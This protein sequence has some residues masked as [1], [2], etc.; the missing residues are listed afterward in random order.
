MQGRASRLFYC[1]VSFVLLLLK[2]GH[3]GVRPA[4]ERR[5]HAANM[6]NIVAALLRTTLFHWITSTDSTLPRPLDNRIL[7][8]I[9][10]RS[11]HLDQDLLLLKPPFEAPV[12]GCSVRRRREL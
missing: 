2:P 8:P 5:R 3:V 9:S 6:C 10:I 7:N 11:E 1:I 12:T 4:R